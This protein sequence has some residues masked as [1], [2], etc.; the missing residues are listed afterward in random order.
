MEKEKGEDLKQ[1]KG[2]GERRNKEKE[3]K[4]GG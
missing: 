4:G 2:F 1:I 3:R